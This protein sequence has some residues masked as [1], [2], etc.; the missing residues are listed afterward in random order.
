MKEFISRTWM[1]LTGAGTSISFKGIEEISTNPNIKD[2]TQFIINHDPLWHYLLIGILGAL[3][4]LLF[5]IFWCWL[6][7]KFPKLQKLDNEK[8]IR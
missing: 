5:K 6:K 1:P 2:A 7:R 8:I 4:G 3:G